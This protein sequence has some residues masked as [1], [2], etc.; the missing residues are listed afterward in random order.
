MAL[1]LPEVVSGTAL[2][3]LSPEDVTRQLHQWLSVAA[4]FDH[5]RLKSAGAVAD[6]AGSDTLQQVPVKLI[7]RGF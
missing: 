2:T 6:W 7:E 4:A 3:Q 5:A 1:S